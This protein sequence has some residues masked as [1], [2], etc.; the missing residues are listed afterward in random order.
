MTTQE[1]FARAKAQGRAAL[2]PYLTA[3][4]PSREGFL[5]AVEEVLPYADLLEI[6]LPYSD[7]LGDGPVIQRASEVALKKGM[8]VQGVLELFR[9]VRSLTDK[10]LFLMTYLNPILAW[11]PERFFSLFRQAGATGLILPDLPPDEDPALVRLAQEIGLETVFLLAPTSTDR[12]IETVVAYAT[13]FVYAVS[14]TGVT[15][16]RERLPEEVGDLVRRIRAKT[17]LPVAVGFGVS[18]RSTAAQ[19]AVADGVVVG[20]ALVRA[21]EGNR[22]LAPLLEEVLE[23]LYQREPA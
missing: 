13:G 19:A 6:G 18:G 10:P 9:E 15:G 14:V 5:R 21:L 17:P 22:P 1:A 20:S 3:G 7:P 16:E 4:F 2:I 11:G 8:S 12:R 23:G